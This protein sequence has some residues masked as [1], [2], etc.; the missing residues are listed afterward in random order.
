MRRTDANCHGSF[1]SEIPDG[2]IS[3]SRVKTNERRNAFCRIRKGRVR[4]RAKLR[5][6][7]STNLT[8]KSDA[9]NA[10]ARA[11]LPKFELTSACTVDELRK[12][13]GTSKPIYFKCRFAI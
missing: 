13:M 2:R 9:L 3:L 5:Q 11:D 10:Q 8:R 1:L 4:L 7:R 6:N 12:V